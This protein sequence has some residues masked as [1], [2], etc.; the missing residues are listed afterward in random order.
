[1]FDRPIQGHGGK[2]S[3]DGVEMPF[4]DQLVP[5]VDWNARYLNSPRNKRNLAWISHQA[6]NLNLGPRIYT[7]AMIDRIKAKADAMWERLKPDIELEMTWK[8]VPA[9]WIKEHADADEFDRLW[10]EAGG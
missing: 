5:S 1:M 3:V 9:E 6:A 7:Y 10:K 4:K 2:M 8:P